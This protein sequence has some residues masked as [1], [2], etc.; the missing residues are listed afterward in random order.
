MDSPNTLHKDSGKECWP[1]FKLTESCLPKGLSSEL[2]TERPFGEFFPLEFCPRVQLLCHSGLVCSHDP[3]MTRYCSSCWQF[4]TLTAFFLQS[5]WWKSSRDTKTYPKTSKK[6][7]RD[8][9]HFQDQ[10]PWKQPPTR[11]Y[12]HKAVRINTKFHRDPGGYRCQRD[13]KKT[14]SNQHNQFKED[15]I[16]AKAKKA[17]P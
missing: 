8:R 14:C 5:C 13:A 15:A 4:L 12:R 10:S 9:Y 2:L 16:W 6:I 17:L 1:N 7:P 11:S 3:R